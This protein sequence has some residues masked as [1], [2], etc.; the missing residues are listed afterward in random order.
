MRSSKMTSGISSPDSPE[1]AQKTKKNN[2]LP[3]EF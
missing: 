2:P 1:F 3:P